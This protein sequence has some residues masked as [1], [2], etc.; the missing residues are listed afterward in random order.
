MNEI[1]QARAFRA[2]RA[3]IDRMVGIAF[4]VDDVLRDILGGIALAVHDQAAAYRAVRA[5]VA[6]FM[7]VGELEVA[8]LL[9]EGRRRGHAQRAQARACKADTGDLEELTTVEIHRALLI[10]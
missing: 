4:D 10:R 8:H 2:Q 9:G 1:Q 6:G 5:G 3:A 7:G